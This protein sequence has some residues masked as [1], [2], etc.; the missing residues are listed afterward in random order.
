MDF[1]IA[2]IDLGGDSE[3]AWSSFWEG[4]A[5]LERESGLAALG[6]DDMAPTDTAARVAGWRDQRD[7][8]ASVLLAVA[9][10]APAP[11]GSGSVR[12][13]LPARGETTVAPDAVLGTVVASVSVHDNTHLGNVSLT[14]RPVARLRGVG[15]SLLAA[16]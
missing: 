13:S 5:D 2:D 14:V 7:G 8:R 4:V 11:A 9:G 16:A 6:Y 10:R 12:R 3:G 1:H 15:R